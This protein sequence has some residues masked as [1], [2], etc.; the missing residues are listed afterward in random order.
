M[1]A[2]TIEK[3]KKNTDRIAGLYSLKLQSRSSCSRC[4]TGRDRKSPEGRN[5]PPQWCYVDKVLSHEAYVTF[6]EIPKSFAKKCRAHHEQNMVSSRPQPRRPDRPVNCNPYARKAHRIAE[7]VNYKGSEQA[8]GPNEDKC[9]KGT[10]EC[11]KPELEDGPED[12]MNKGNMGMCETK[13]VK[14]VNMG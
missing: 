8:P 13:L 5:V 11:S 9:S 7:G 1:L 14:V 3:K 6:C 4:R 2:H 12:A 10:E